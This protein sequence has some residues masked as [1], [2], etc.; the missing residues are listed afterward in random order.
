M[1]K[2]LIAISQSF[3]YGA[4]YAARTR[5]LSKLLQ[6][7]GYYVD[8]L[9]DYPSEGAEIEDYGNIFTVTPTLSS[10]IKALVYLPII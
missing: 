1:K 10:G 8:I 2:I 5:A 9:C 4:A 3:P 6:E 7:A